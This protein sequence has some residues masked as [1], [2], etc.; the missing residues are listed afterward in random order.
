MPDDDYEIENAQ[1]VAARFSLR[2]RRALVTG[3]SL[4]IG[5]EISLVL[6][7]AGADVAVHYAKAADAAFGHSNAADEVVTT[8]AKMGRR[9]VPIE[10]DFEQPGEA[11]RCVEAARKALGG[12]DVLVICAS[13]QYRVPFEEVTPEQTERQIQIN[14]KATVE[15]L[16]A[17]LP[18][19]KEAGWGRVLTIGSINQ[20][21]PE[22]VLAIYAALKS[23]QHN[24]SIN[25]ARE[26]APF[27]VTIN[28]L[29]PGLI[30][31]E[32]N[33]WRRVDAAAW[34]EIEQ[35][36]SPMRRAG[37][38]VEMAGAALLLCSDAGSFITGADLQATGGRHL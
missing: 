26:Y 22:S 24:L 25:L 31:T 29:S 36:S 7:E 18:A 10:A 38:P 21:K 33:R 14:F 30:A 34:K 12:V 3:G 32:R 23:A 19:M 15:L 17:A 8:I 9:G 6:A 4:S 35:G 28:N 16:Q 5:R 1:R 11:I 27:D 37:R 2:G 20:T 13:I